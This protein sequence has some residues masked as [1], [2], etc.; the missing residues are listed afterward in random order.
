MR[1]TPHRRLLLILAGGLTAVIAAVVAV[2]LL[3]TPA[4]PRC[5]CPPDCGRP[6]IGTP[7]ESNPR[8]TAA[9]GGFSVE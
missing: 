5:V 9:D 4:I 2:S 3:V 8:F 6:P 7:V 1:H